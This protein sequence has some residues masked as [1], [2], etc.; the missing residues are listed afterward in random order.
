MVNSPREVDVLV[1]GY[2][3]VGQLLSLQLTRK[4]WSVAVVEKWPD[5]Y[6]LPRA[7]HF[8][9]EIGR[10]LQSAGIRPDSTPVIEPYDNY[11]T[12]RNGDHEDLIQLDWRGEGPSGWSTANF[13][14]QPELEREIHSRVVAEGGVQLCRGWQVTDIVED[15]E[16]ATVTARPTEIPSGMPDEARSQVFSA[17]YVVGCDGA[18]SFVARQMGVGYEDLGFEFDWLIVDMIPEEPMEFDPPAWQWCNPANPTT[19]VP[20]GPGRRRWEFMRMPKER[21]QDLNSEQY[22]WKRVA[23]WGLTPDNSTLEKHAVYTFRARWATSWREGR[24]LLAGDAAHLMPPFAG[25]GMCSG[26][27]DVA[28]LV[29]RLDRVLSGASPDALLDSYGPERTGHVRYW[30]EFSMGLGNVICV[31]D[32]DAAAARDAG[33]QAVLADPSLA[34][35]QP[36]PPHL[37]GGVLGSHPLAGFLTPQGRVTGS[38]GSGLLDDVI[39]YGWVV[40]SRAGSP[41][42]VLGADT[43][44]WAQANGVQVLSVGGEDADLQDTEGTYAAWFETL[45]AD[46]AVIRPDFY[47]YDAVPLDQLEQTLAR[48]REQLDHVPATAPA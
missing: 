3:P 21:V 13:F 29:W 44:A 41:S 1:V 46:T 40:L 17:R 24:K 26:M 43:E 30:I 48:L 22:A 2:G 19:V 14:S 18:N 33:M 27:R 20:G 8:D 47:L 37:S 38:G 45:G 31:T 42:Q 34:P 23:P 6:P 36:P 4:G 11:Y 16:R 5:F 7:V 10:V 9:D 15:G 39:G 12:W 28:N 25:Q 32:E 35:E